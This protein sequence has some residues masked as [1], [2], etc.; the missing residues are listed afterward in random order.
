MYQWDVDFADGVMRN[1]ALSS[2]IRMAAIAATKFQ[3][4]VATEP[5]YG[6]NKGEG[7]TI[8]RIRNIAEPTTAKVG[9]RDRIP[10]DPFQHSS[11][12]ITVSEWGRGVEYSHKSQ[13]L[14]HFDPEDKIQKKLRQQMSLVL[15][16]AAAE[17]FKAAKVKFIPTSLSG[18]T[19]DPDGVP[20][21]QATQNLTVQ[22]VFVVR[23]YMAD[24]LHVPGWDGGEEYICLASTKACRGV[25]NDPL[26]REW[27]KSQYADRTFYRGEIG[28][29]ENVRFIEINH[30]QALANNKGAG[31][32]LGEALFFGDDAVAMAV[33]EDPELRAA[34]PGDFGRQRAVA[35]YGVLAYGLVWDTANDG[36]ARV[37]HVTSS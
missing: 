26:F 23:D 18:G 10:I 34:I 19:F 15:D 9:E 29:I 17:A 21:V 13:L 4:F 11:V 22:H 12:T 20:S 33:A 14:A 32:V 24:T 35:W 30:T 25:K 27:S 7:V 5:G 2:D 3:Q 16:T 1:H 31:S 36:E 37:I 8:T 28:S 6:R